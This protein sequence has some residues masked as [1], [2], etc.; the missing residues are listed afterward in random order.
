MFF[1]ILCSFK[2]NVLYGDNYFKKCLFFFFFL[3]HTS[4]EG[5][6]IK[7]IKLG[8]GVFLL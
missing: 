8:V 4:F 5:K 2:Q 3:P 6:H 1:I 7:G